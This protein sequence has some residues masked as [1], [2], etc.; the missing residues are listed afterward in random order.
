MALSY[1]VPDMSCAH[2]VAAI[3]NAVKTVAP[4]A[5]VDVDLATHHVTVTGT[6]EHGRIDAAI[7]DA[8]YTP[9]A[10]ALK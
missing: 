10:P 5:S 1:V 6:D 9:A 2:C 7:R 8:G 3:T 4:D